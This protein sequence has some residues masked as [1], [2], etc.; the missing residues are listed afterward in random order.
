MNTF[1]NLRRAPRTAQRLLAGA[2]AAAAL[3]AVLPAQAQTAGWKDGG[4][5]TR[6][7]PGDAGS[8]FYFSTATQFSITACTQNTFGYAFDAS[9]PSASRNYATLLTA[10]TLNKPVS[11]HL[12]GGCSSVGGGTTRPLVD[13]I[14][15]TETGYY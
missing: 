11:I 8:Y 1:D 2:L 12:T 4:A 13:T 10:Y 5:V 3:S 7:H 9:S 14:E 6:L 15:I